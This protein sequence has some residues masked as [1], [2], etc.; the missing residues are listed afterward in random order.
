MPF[1]LD[2]VLAATVVI[3]ALRVF[4]PD[5]RHL[6]RRLLRAGVRVG[7][8]ELLKGGHPADTAPSLT[9]ASKDEGAR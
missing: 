4:A 7:A 9:A 2:D 8:D 3:T 1:T 5:A 6:T